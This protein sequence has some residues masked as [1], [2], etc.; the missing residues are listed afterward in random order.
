MKKYIFLL[1]LMLLSFNTFSQQKTDISNLISRKNELKIATIKPFL[2]EALELEFERIINSSN[3]VGC[4]FEYIFSKKDPTT[5]NRPQY[6]FFADIFYR[7]YFL[8]TKKYGISGFFFQPFISYSVKQN[9]PY[10][11]ST[12]DPGFY[13][14]QNKY[15]NNTG[16]G[17]VLGKK[18]T[19]K[20]GFNIQILGG[21][22]TIF[23][24]YYYNT[25]DFFGSLIDY[26]ML[27]ADIYIGYRF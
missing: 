2:F 1:L 20:Q 17:S 6:L 3:S 11:D 14:P 10:Y 15:S 5:N 24:K 19:V 4:N 9:I 21:F 23:P 27:R 7:K 12:D 8:Q 22:E 13:H 26:I 25:F 18:W 16:F